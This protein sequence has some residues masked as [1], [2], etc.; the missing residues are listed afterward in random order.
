MTRGRQ[1]L[2]A[3]DEAI[4]IAGKRGLVM[5]YQHRRGDVCDFSIMSPGLVSFVC[6]MR[7]L[8]LSSTPEDILHDFSSVIGQLRFIASSPAISRELWLCTPRGAWR[9][10]RILD[11]SII[12]LDRNGMPLANNGTAIAGA[13][14]A[15]AGTKKTPEPA[16]Q[17]NKKTRK[18]QQRVTRKNSEPAKK[19]APDSKPTKD[20]EKRGNTA[21]GLNPAQGP[22][23][24]KDLKSA[25]T[26]E[27]ISEPVKD[28]G[29]A[30]DITPAPEPENIPEH[31]KKFLRRRK[32]GLEQ[33]SEPA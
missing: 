12:E 19:S 27:K 28:P 17:N 29:P 14:S 22:E 11:S 6:V 13:S 20:P 32:R 25:T 9:F 3:Q 5:H 18:E 4:P 26:P 1:P 31:I 15:G 16:V 10:F 2:K 23:P 21:Q 7:L 8:R 30:Q 33:D 24:E